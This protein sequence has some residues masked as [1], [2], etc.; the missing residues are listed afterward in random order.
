MPNWCEGYLKIR[1]KKKDLINFIENEFVIVKSESVISGIEYIDIKME[2]DGLGECR[3]EYKSSFLKKIMLKNTRRFFIKG[4]ELSFYYDE[5]DE[6][7]ICYI[8]LWIEQAWYIDVQELL[9]EHSKKYHVDFNIYA[10][11]R[12]MEF[13]QYITVV[14][15]KLI[16]NEEREY[17]DFQFEAINPELGG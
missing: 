14:E 13:E 11:E 5:E 4:E 8:T 12:G 15:G 3:F 9:V 1:G 6:N 2:D 10:S 17:T 16:K 7:A